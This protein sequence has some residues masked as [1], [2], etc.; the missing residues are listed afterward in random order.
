M[1]K[2]LILLLLAFGSISF[3]TAYSQDN[4]PESRRQRIIDAEYLFLNEEYSEALRIFRELAKD[5]PDNAN[6]NY[7]I[8]LCYQ[9]LPFEAGRSIRPLEIAIKDLTYDYN[10]G[11]YREKKAPIHAL[12]FLGNGYHINGYID[13]AIGVYTRYRDTLPATDIYNIKMVER[14]IMSCH[15]AKEIRRNPVPVEISN[16]G[17]SINGPMADFNPI[18]PKDGKTMYFTT[19]TYNVINENEQIDG[20]SRQLKLMGETYFRIMESQKEGEERWSAPRDITDELNTRGKCVTLSISAKGDE[21]LLYRNDWLD[22]GILDYKSGTIY[23]SQK[24]G[25]KWKPIKKLGSNINSS[26]YESHATISPDGNRIYFTSD[27]KGGQGGLDIWYSDKQGKGWGKAVNL[28]P[29]INTP[30]DEETPFILGDGKTLFFASEGHYNMGGFDIFVSMQSSSGEWTEPVNLGYPINTTK[31]DLFFYPTK[32][33]KTGYYAVERH[34]GYLT[35]GGFDIYEVIILDKHQEVS[36]PV[37]INGKI[38]LEDG[39]DL[40]RTAYVYVIDTIKND[41]LIKLKPNIETQTYSV[42][43][44]S[45][46]YKIIFGS[47]GYRDLDRVVFIPETSESKSFVV[48][49]NLLVDGF[50]SEDYFFIQNIYFEY[51]AYELDPEGKRIAEQLFSVMN[52]HPDLFVEVIGH[53]DARGLAIYNHKL[54]LQRSRTVINYLVDKGIDKNRFVEKGRGADANIAINDSEAG[55]RL[56]RRVEVRVLRGDNE[57]ILT[58]QEEIPDE[59]RFKDYNRWSVI[60]KESLYRVTERS[61]F[62]PLEEKG[63]KVEWII[64]EEGYVYYFGDF[65]TKASASQALNFALERGFD[66]RL[67]DYFRLNKMNKFVVRSQAEKNTTYTIQLKAID[68]MILLDSFELGDEVKEVKTSDGFYRYTYKTFTD[69]SEAQKELEKIIEKGFVN[70]FIID[71]DRLR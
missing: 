61:I 11:S 67:V 19:E 23:Y 28:G 32:D 4:I 20:R 68:T 56:N 2:A 69:L 22:G 70:A 57:K 8:G 42:S 60:V 35:F 14:Q 3:F 55:R 33:G 64:A 27:R 13:E 54:S 31:D 39:R 17:R 29:V 63:H 59:L 21:M 25:D 15:N 52:E 30:H 40:D 46:F 45:G 53:T 1:K 41:T 49:A 44:P 26:S 48:N 66:A 43:L 7:R 16:V 24:I 62:A 37:E 58:A 38:T 18:L 12:Y 10:E 5:D 36:V 34:E 47:S 51:N 71:V 9:N 6:Y 65:D 50:R